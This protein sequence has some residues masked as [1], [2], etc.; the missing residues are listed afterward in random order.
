MIK[1]LAAVA[2]FD[3]ALIIERTR[4]GQDRVRAA[5]AHLG[6]PPKTTEAQRQVI[7]ARLF[8]G[9]S[10][11][12]VARDFKTSRATVLTVRDNPRP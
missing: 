10:V 1:V 4:A 5:G 9:E 11:T 8:K 3:R 6:R 2:D 12:P 7:R